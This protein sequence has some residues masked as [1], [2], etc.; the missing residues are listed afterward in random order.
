MNNDIKKG[1]GKVNSNPFLIPYT[2]SCNT[3]NDVKSLKD[4]LEKLS[5]QFG[6]D[7]FPNRF[8]RK[9]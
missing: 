6:Y 5:L 8:H 2:I 3:K 9:R 4:D 1:F 7:S